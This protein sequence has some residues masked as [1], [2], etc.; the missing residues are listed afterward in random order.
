MGL[1]HQWPSPPDHLSVFKGQW[2][3]EDLYQRNQLC[4]NTVSQTLHSPLP[5]AVNEG[6]NQVLW[7]QSVFLYPTF[8]EE[9][10]VKP[11][12]RRKTTPKQLIVVGKTTVDKNKY[13]YPPFD[14]KRKSPRT[15]Q[16]LKGHKDSLVDGSQNSKIEIFKTKR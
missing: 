7:T 4:K 15:R 11:F 8:K 5:G 1:R 2:T 9:L 6:T 12:Q 10:N 13:Y 14:H 16:F 3:D